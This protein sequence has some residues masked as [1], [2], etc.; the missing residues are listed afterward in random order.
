[1]FV[2]N[3]IVS[4]MLFAPSYGERVDILPKGTGKKGKGGK[5]GMTQKSRI[6]VRII[7]SAVLVSAMLLTASVTGRDGGA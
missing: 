6:S 4:G 5:G 7:V 1:M 2:I 3:D